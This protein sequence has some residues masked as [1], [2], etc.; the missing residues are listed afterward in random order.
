MATPE[1]LV[2]RHYT[3]AE[4][5]RNF[6][7]RGWILNAEEIIA[8]YAPKAAA[9]RA[10]LPNRLDIP[11][12]PMPQERLDLF[13]TTVP[14]APVLVFVHGGRWLTFTKEQKSYVAEPF[15]PAGVHCAVLN[16][17]KLPT[18]TLPVMVEQ[19]RRGVAWVWRN[20]ASFGGDASRAYIW[21]HSSGAHLA[22]MALVIDW[23]GRGL[24][25]DL[26]KGAALISGPYDMEAVMLSARSSY[27]KL[28]SEQIPR[29]SPLVLANRIPCPVIVGWAE[30][31]TDEFR[32]QSEALAEALRTSG[33][34]VA[35]I[36]LPKLNHFETM[37]NLGDIDNPIVRRLLQ[38]IQ[39]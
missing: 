24:P 26:L 35:S 36:R 5:D 7:Q 31:D 39:R 6:D 17:A 37:E 14:N 10:R 4:L 21:G 12:G 34:L 19:V 8:R 30:G 23:P 32:R 20:A 25:D 27:V 3:Q 22:A 1:P 13:L 11:Y 18:V 16:F 2:Y 33:R 15:V 29:Y 9:T 38:L 28:T